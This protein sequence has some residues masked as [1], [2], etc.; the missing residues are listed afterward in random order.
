[1]NFDERKRV[2][3]EMVVDFLEAYTV[4]RGLSDDAQA[5]RINSVADAFARRM[6][7]S[8]DYREQ[9]EKVFDKIRDTHISNSWPAQAIFVMAMPAGDVITPKAAET[10]EPASPF[11]WAADAMRKGDPVPE[12]YVW[13][14]P[15]QQMLS[16]GEIDRATMDLYRRSSIE[17]HRSVYRH[18]A[19][20]IVAGK[21]GA[22]A[23][24][25]LSAGAA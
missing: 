6:P 20:K 25:Y 18:E 17:H 21:F 24:P 4:P 19:E 8:G 12:R 9:V 7:T 2:S 5:K 3:T 23:L 22:V 16:A 11:A 15:S 10:F 13:G 14:R 1:M